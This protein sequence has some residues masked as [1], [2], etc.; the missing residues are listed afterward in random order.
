MHAVFLAQELEIGEVIVPRFPGA[1]SAWGMLETEI[2]KDSGRAYFTPLAML[3]HDDLAATLRA[4]EE[5]AYA[6]LEEEG[7]GRDTGRVEHALDIRYVGQEY[8]LTIPLAG[9]DEPLD[10]DFDA[11]L[12]DRFHAA[13]ELRF[14]HANP[15]ALVELVVV[16][17]TALGDLGRVAPARQQDGRRARPAG[18]DAGGRL[19]PR[20]RPD[21]D[22]ASATTSR[23]A[24]CSRALRW[25]RRR[26][27]R[28]SSRPAPRSASTRSARSSSPPPRRTGLMALTE[29][30]VDPITTEII[31]SAFTAAA[32]EMNA[33][34]IRSA[35]TPV[36]YEMKDC[37]VALLD[38]EHRVLGQ[39]AGLPIFLGN[40]E[41]CTRLTE[42]MYGREIW[43]ADD[44][45]IMNDSYLTG[46][47]LNDM[48]VF[49]PIFHDGELVGFA[50]SRAHWL[51]VGREGRR[52][53]DELDRDLPGGH[54]PR[55]DQGG[56]GRDPAHRT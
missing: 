16:R 49:G 48:T 52:R 27:R 14:G 28:R 5:E 4:L 53:A 55:P 32:D 31:R 12:A 13:H 17:T 30:R 19:R 9:A 11:N 47:H 42:E 54:P 23:P 33:T 45:W 20:G 50:A 2:R 46:T 18:G 39:S 35:Y 41:I 22:R 29:R 51:D 10:E 6:S 26:R 56:R 40:L 25:S 34:L 15:G 38:S 7:I 8:T 37:S 1:F 21:D 36:I 43:R 24:W 44:I 3:D